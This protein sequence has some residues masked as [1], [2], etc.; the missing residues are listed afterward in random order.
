MLQRFSQL[1]AFLLADHGCNGKSSLRSIVSTP[2]HGKRG[3]A[4]V[5]DETKKDCVAEETKT[6]K[7]QGQTVQSLLAR[8]LAIPGAADRLELFTRRA[9]TSTT[10]THKYF[11][12][13][14]E[15]S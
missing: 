3:R 10:L 12:F 6:N 8:Q 14:V 5:H 9:F 7:Q 15:V 13:S 1:C 4:R 11:A 2:E